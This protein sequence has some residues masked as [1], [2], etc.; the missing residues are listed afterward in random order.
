MSHI[1]LFHRNCSYFCYF[2]SYTIFN[3]WKR[4]KNKCVDVNI[5]R[6]KKSTS[7]CHFVNSVQ[8]SVTIFYLHCKTAQLRWNFRM[9]SIPRDKSREMF[10]T[11]KLKLTSSVHAQGTLPGSL[12]WFRGIQF[13]TPLLFLFEYYS[14]IYTSFSKTRFSQIQSSY[15]QKLLFSGQF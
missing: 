12:G 8:R 2:S 3:Q 11:I 7:T 1:V 9:K 6:S 4:R 10:F 14:G 5:S 13:W 15:A